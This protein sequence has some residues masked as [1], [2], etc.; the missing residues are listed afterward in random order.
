MLINNRTLLTMK[1]KKIQYK[2]QSQYKK[3]IHKHTHKHT[4]KNNKKH[5]FYINKCKFDNLYLLDYKILENYLV[6][7][8]LH[9]DKMMSVIENNDKII[10]KQHNISYEDFCKFT[11]K[12]K[13]SKI[14]TKSIIADVFFYNINSDFLDKRFYPIQ[15]YLVNIL[16]IKFDNITKKD[17]IYTYLQ[18]R[19]DFK[20]YE[21]YFIETFPINDFEK[22]KFPEYYILRPIDSFSGQGITY[23][24]NKKE[25]QKEIENYKKLKNHKGV[26]YGNDVIASPYITNLLLFQGK[27]FH[28]RM[29]YIVSCIN[30]V[31]N[32]FLLNNSDIITAEKPFDMELPFTADKHDTHLKSSSIDLI[33]KEHFTSDNLGIEIIEEHKNKIYE[34]SKKICKILTE[35]IIEKS[36]CKKD[37]K[38]ILYPEQENGYHI[39]GLD[40]FVNK[41]F[42]CIL[43]ECNEHTGFETFTEIG[44]QKLSNYIYKWINEII[45]EPLFKYNNPK[46]ARKHKTYIKIEN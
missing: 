46:I 1:T 45:L 15:K 44:N 36:D 3:Q 14:N 33:F 6:K 5:Y 25:L 12:I 28:L 32:S 38:K 35:M 39:F 42:E 23:I 40:I 11:K 29:Y 26:I 10:A 4:H 17:N 21:K 31:I 2:K 34:S 13:P 19:K 37:C 8:G 20:E 7:L 27:K 9:P 43:I 24:K 30:G 41:D 16:N 18:S 22:Y